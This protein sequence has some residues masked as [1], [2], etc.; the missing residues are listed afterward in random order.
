MPLGQEVFFCDRAARERRTLHIF[1][2]KGVG[3]LTA[4]LWSG[5]CAF[6]VAILR[7]FVVG[8][9]RA[10][11]GRTLRFQS[12][13]A[14]VILGG[15]GEWLL[16]PGHGLAA[17]RT[18]RGHKAVEGAIAP[19]VTLKPSLMKDLRNVEVGSG[20]QRALYKVPNFLD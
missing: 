15:L 13:L 7:G 18:K 4:L 9:L 12:H 6:A 3:T 19:S 20:S 16:E 2:P 14:T 17:L 11:R 1:E 10:V 5:R 8:T